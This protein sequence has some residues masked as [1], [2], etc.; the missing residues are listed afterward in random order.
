[1]KKEAL[2]NLW[3]LMIKTHNINIHINVLLLRWH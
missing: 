2:T 1:M 3:L